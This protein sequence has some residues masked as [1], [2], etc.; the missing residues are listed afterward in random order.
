MTQANERF[1][2]VWR[3]S[4]PAAVVSSHQVCGDSLGLWRCGGLAG[5]GVGEQVDG[6]EGEEGVEGIA[7]AGGDEDD[8]VSGEWD[9]GEV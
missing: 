5:A 2:R 3:A 9:E 1:S 8:E 4:G 6:S 7:E